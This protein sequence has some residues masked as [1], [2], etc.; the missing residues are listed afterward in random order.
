MT[1]IDDTPTPD[2]AVPYAAPRSARPQQHPQHM[3]PSTLAAGEPVPPQSRSQRKG[4]GRGASGRREVRAGGAVPR[5]AREGPRACY[6]RRTRARHVWGALTRKDQGH[7]RAHEAKERG[8]SGTQI[9]GH[10]WWI[11]RDRA[12]RAHA[13]RPVRANARGRGAQSERG[14]STHANKSR[15]A[16]KGKRADVLLARCCAGG[17]PHH[18]AWFEGA[19]VI[20][21]CGERGMVVTEDAAGEDAVRAAN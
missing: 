20:R 1:P 14:E 12:A 3:G 7:G 6:A 18:G 16:M 10:G 13:T 15:A 21:P 11:L 19:R 8:G 4:G 5:R 17:G 9:G 2:L